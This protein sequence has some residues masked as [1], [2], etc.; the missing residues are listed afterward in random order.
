MFISLLA[1][2]GHHYLTL[3]KQSCKQMHVAHSAA[4]ACLAVAAAQAAKEDGVMLRS[5]A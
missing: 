1:V 5:E 3:Q 2:S 4:I